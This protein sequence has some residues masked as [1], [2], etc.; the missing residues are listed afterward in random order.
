MSRTCLR[1]ISRI[2]FADYLGNADGNVQMLQNS[3]AD[4]PGLDAAPAAAALVTAPAEHSPDG[5]AV[6]LDKQ[7]VQISKN[8]TQQQLS[9]NL[10]QVYMGMFKTALGSTGS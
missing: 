1:I 2:S 3:A 8:D 10:Y 7:L 4:L 5:N 9:T 6:S